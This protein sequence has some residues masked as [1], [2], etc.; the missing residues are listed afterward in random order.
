MNA[1]DFTLDYRLAADC[2]PLGTLDGAELLLMNNANF[3]WFILVPHTEHTEFFELGR[4]DQQTLLASINAI[5]AFIKQEFSSE[6]LNIAAIGNI[7]KQLHIHIV[8]RNSND[9]CWPGVVWGTKHRS[10]Y[11]LPEIER[12]RAALAVHLGEAFTPAH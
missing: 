5:S 8:G 4:T 2:Y 10:N 9:V 6:K 1:G 12:I 7:V 11:A 3:P